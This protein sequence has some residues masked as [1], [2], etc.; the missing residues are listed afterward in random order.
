[1]EIRHFRPIVSLRALAFTDGE[2]SC[3]SI[4]EHLTKKRADFRVMPDRHFSITET[5]LLWNSMTSF[6][7]KIFMR[8]QIFKST[9]DP[10]V[11]TEHSMKFARLGVLGP[12]D[13]SLHNWFAESLL[14]IR[15][16]LN[17]IIKR[18][19]LREKNEGGRRSRSFIAS[20]R[21]LD[22]I[23]VITD[24]PSAGIYRAF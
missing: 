18:V 21:I 24:P 19:C 12:S 11:G 3:Y 5:D 16:L 15:L 7:N 2:T 9:P 14:Y 10:F 13:N 20:C 4:K 22:F 1:M 6:E 23:A 17:V 8:Q